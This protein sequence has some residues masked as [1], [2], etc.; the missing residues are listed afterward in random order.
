MVPGWVTR[1]LGVALCAAVIGCGGANG[2]PT[3]PVEGT[4]TFEGQPV[5]AGNLTFSPIANFDKLEA[6]APATAAVKPDGSFVLGTNSENDGAVIG[7][8]RVAYSPPTVD[9][10]TPEWDGNGPPPK[11]PE[12]PFA[13]LVP[14]ETEVEVKDD[15]NK[16]SIELVRAA[17]GR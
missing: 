5:T 1:T 12:V 9:V 15:E 10:Q 6:G 17:A 16:V 7:R 4:V 2:L 8:H 3:A 13:G 11:A 14:K